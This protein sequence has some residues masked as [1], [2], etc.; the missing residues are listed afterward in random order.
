MRRHPSG[1]NIVTSLYIHP[2][3]FPAQPK[4]HY[5][6]TFVGKHLISRPL[7]LA[8]LLLAAHVACLAQPWNVLGSPAFSAGY[9]QSPSIALDGSG[10]PWLAYQDAGTGS[11]ATVMNFNGSSW[12]TAGSA[13]F[14]AGTATNTSLAISPSGTPYVVFRDITQGNRATVMKF[15]GTSWVTVGLPGF[16]SDVVFFTTIAISASGVPYVAWERQTDGKIAV[17][18][19]TG[20]YW[21]SVG[22]D[23]FSAGLAYWPRVAVDPDGNPWVVYEDAVNGDGATVMKYN[24]TSWTT[25]GGPSFSAGAVIYTSMAIDGS[26]VPYVVYSDVALGHRISVMKFS[27]GA[28]TNVGIAGFSQGVASIVAI[29]LSNTGVP[30]VVFSDGA[31]G[32]GATVMK[33]RSGAWI[34]LG[35]PGDDISITEVYGVDIAVDNVGRAIVAYST[36]AD[37]RKATV[38]K[39]G[40][41]PSDIHGTLSLCESSVTTLSNDIGGGTWASS[42]PPVAAIGLSTGIVTA[43]T[44]G[45]TTISY[46]LYGITVTALLT[47]YP[48]PWSGVLYGATSVCVGETATLI[49]TTQGGVWWSGDTTIATVS[50]GVF[51][52][53]SGGTGVIN[54]TV[55]NGC[56]SATAMQSIHVYPQP[57]AGIIT[58]AAGLCL[59]DTLTLGNAVSGGEWHA[60]NTNATITAGIVT[61]HATGA[62]TITYTVANECGADTV[63]HILGI[64]TAPDTGAITGTGELCTNEQ[65]TLT[66]SVT[67][68]EWVSSDP[69]VATVAGGV[70]TGVGHGTVQISYSVSNGACTLAATRAV[71]VH[72]LY[73]PSTSLIAIPDTIAFPGQSVTFFVS[74]TYGGTHPTYKWYIDGVLQPADTGNSMYRQVYGNIQVTCVA[75]S[76]LPC[77]GP[78]T[79]T[80]NTVVVAGNSFLEAGGPPADK[81]AFKVFPNPG[82]GSFSMNISAAGVTTAR[83]TVA[84]MLGQTVDE[85][86]VPAGRDVPL[87]LHVPAGVYFIA[88]TASGFSHTQKIV[89]Q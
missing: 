2:A 47:V 48:Q 72:A 63:A 55:T 73:V 8:L 58:G 44:T 41:D 70:V 29:A 85:W 15:N 88:V 42:N 25:V 66:E 76:N 83:V 30:Y 64:S 43:L 75:T 24:G 61:A 3:L 68:G 50:G 65:V 69:A 54:F 86:Q 77:A 13:G 60:S 38:V 57:D 17:M 19:F 27:G 45:T 28:W 78:L 52:G 14:S 71:V 26:G 23:G 7:L 9:I 79:D 59:G 10:L 39:L 82:N 33:Y 89:V 51:T 20:T 37:G 49:D 18:K 74:E 11:R 56:S 31:N 81:D 34:N 16:S 21:Q 62:D 6:K 67:G 22:T 1:H 4:H 80:S 36:L 40:N 12:T 35:I 5:M 87:S 84:D 53:I 46:T 32:N